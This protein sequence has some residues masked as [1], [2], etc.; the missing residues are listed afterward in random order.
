MRVHIIGPN[1]MCPE[2]Y[3]FHVHAEG[4]PDVKRKRLYRWADHAWDTE[5]AYEMDSMQEVV[6][7]MY[8]GQLSDNADD[9]EWSDWHAYEPDFKWFPC[10]K[11]LLP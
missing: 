9:P 1:L 11:G 5:H 4:C 2:G 3:T 6:E 8:D 10:V 7:F